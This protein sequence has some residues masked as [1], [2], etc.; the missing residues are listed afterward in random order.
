MVQKVLTLICLIFLL[1]TSATRTAPVTKMPIESISLVTEVEKSE[2]EVFS[3]SFFEAQIMK[4]S[5]GKQFKADGTIVT[6]KA[7]A[8]GIAQ[9]M[10]STWKWLKKKRILPKHYDIRNAEHQKIAQKIYMLYLYDY[11]YG[12]NAQGLSRKELAIAAYNC[13]PGRVKRTVR[14]HSSLWKEHLPTETI[15]YLQKLS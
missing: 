14:K 13:G 12:T 5:S 1:N 15:N 3:E 11:D 2:R 10:P 4:E 7:G 8:L 6:S 9:F